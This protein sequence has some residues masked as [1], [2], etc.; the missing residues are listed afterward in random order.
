MFGPVENIRGGYDKQDNCAKHGYGVGD[1]VRDKDDE[2]KEGVVI[3][4]TY[5]REQIRSALMQMF[6]KQGIKVNKDK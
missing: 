5:T 2:T 3:E 6:K 4:P 1:L